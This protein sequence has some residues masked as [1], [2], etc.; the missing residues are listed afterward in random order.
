MDP[1]ALNGPQFLGFFAVSFVLALAVSLFVRR[2][3]RGPVDEPPP[4]SV[5]LDPYE[6]ALLAGG[7]A[8]AINSAIAALVHSGGLEVNK[9]ERKLIAAKGTTAGH[10]LERAVLSAAAGS[11]GST[12]GTELRTVRK[13]AEPTA[14]LLRPRLTDLGLLVGD[15]QAMLMGLLGAVPMLALL[16]LGAMR[17]SQASHTGKPSAFLIILMVVTGIAALILLFKRTLRTRRGDAVLARLTAD[18]ASARATV[19][20]KPELVTAGDI[21]LAV[22]L[23]GV[24][25]LATGPMDALAETLRP[26]PGSS[27]CGTSCGGSSCGG[28]G[29]SCGGGG[30]GGCGGGGGD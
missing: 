25:V 7:E 26:P 15:G 13:G 11:V 20:A 5:K 12:D 4:G 10:D 16:V 9:T 21:A 30:C 27:S 8:A 23:F 3:L 1:F 6:T 22:G 18:A 28:G 29:S 17:L 2:T 19:S 24:A 14:A